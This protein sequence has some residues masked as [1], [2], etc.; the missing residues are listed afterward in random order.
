MSNVL[1]LDPIT[2]E[3]EKPSHRRLRRLS[4]GLA[5]LFT[6]LPAF[7]ALFILA[8][9]VVVL[10]FS[11]YLQMNAQG[12]WFG[13]GLHGA[14]PR[15]IP[16]MVRFSDQP[17]ITHL[18]GIADFVLA[19]VPIFFVFL[20]LRGLFRLYAAG[21]VFAREN[22]THLKRIG[23]WLIAYPFVKFAANMLFQLAGGLDRAWFHVMGVQALV[24]GL[25]VVAIAQVMEFGREIEQEK[26]SFV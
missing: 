12:V 1:A 24:L 22:A 21:T 20:H 16:G 6:A 26:D 11:A 5:L 14:I 25:I 19:A 23:L 3:N 9:I 2:A 15:A 13:I 7:Y 18:A 4:S 10:F 8:G 17:L